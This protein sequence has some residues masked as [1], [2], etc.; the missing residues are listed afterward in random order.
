MN[1]IDLRRL[2]IKKMFGMIENFKLTNK[3]KIIVM[4]KNER[5]LK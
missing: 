5:L 4:I 3:I 1:V 2:G